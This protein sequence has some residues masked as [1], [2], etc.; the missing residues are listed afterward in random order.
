MP[1]KM[2]LLGTHPL[3]LPT[4]AAHNAPVEAFRSHVL[5]QCGKLKKGS[6]THVL[7]GDTVMHLSYMLF[8]FPRQ[9]IRVGRTQGAGGVIGA[10]STVRLDIN[11]A[12]KDTTV[13]RYRTVQALMF[14][15]MIEVVLGTLEITFRVKTGVI[16]G[17][18]PRH[19]RI[20]LLVNVF[21]FAESPRIRRGRTEEAFFRDDSILVVG[22]ELQV[23]S[24][25]VETD[26]ENVVATGS[27]LRF[28]ARKALVGERDGDF[29]RIVANRALVFFHF[30]FC[31]G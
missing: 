9:D 12:V 18:V 17:L 26:A 1:Q 11:G 25:T 7:A 6:A 28:T 29:D 23:G 3:E 24:C 13:A 22:V 19:V 21:G 8:P 4:L 10:L 27:I 15:V 31:V 20:V 5:F 30:W 14:H 16:G 2:I